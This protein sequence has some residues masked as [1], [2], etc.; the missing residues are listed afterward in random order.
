MTTTF[1]TLSDASAAYDALSARLD[2]LTRDVRYGYARIKLQ[3][4]LDGI[5]AGYNFKLPDLDE[6]GTTSVAAVE[7]ALATFPLHHPQAMVPNK[8]AEVHDLLRSMGRYV[9]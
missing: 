8:R 6:N 5:M 4:Q 9:E 2:T 3:P 7:R 1:Q